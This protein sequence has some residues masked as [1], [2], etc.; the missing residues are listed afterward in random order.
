M[1]RVPTLP[2]LEVI[3]GFKGVLDF[4]KWRGIFYVR[5]WPVT[6]PSSLSPEHYQRANLFGEIVRAY[7]F[8]AGPIHDAY[9]T[10]SK[11]TPRT[12]RD[13]HVAAV[14]GHLHERA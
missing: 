9:A 7:A 4:V 11:G 8:L 6:P 2:S 5:R 3:R 14:L 10:E 1:A 12:G 13:L